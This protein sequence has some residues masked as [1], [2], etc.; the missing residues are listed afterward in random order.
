MAMDVGCI[1]NDLP[2]DGKKNK[3]KNRKTDK[4]PRA[5]IEVPPELKKAYKKMWTIRRKK[6]WMLSILLFWMFMSSNLLT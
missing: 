6:G 1:G 2:P 3:Q 4:H 5:L